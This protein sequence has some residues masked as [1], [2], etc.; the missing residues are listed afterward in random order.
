VYGDHATC[1]RLLVSD[2]ICLLHVPERLAEIVADQAII[3]I[4][5]GVSKNLIEANFSEV[6]GRRP[7]F[8]KRA[9]FTDELLV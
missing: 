9:N 8:I 4:D 2:P 3:L 7:C 1:Q 5:D 6:F